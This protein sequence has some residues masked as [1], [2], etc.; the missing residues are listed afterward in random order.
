MGSTDFVRIASS[1]LLEAPEKAFSIK[2]RSMVGRFCGTFDKK[3]P[4]MRSC[5]DY[6]LLPIGTIV[7]YSAWVYIVIKCI[8]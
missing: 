7:K 6:P 2:I 8:L 3:I 1:L 5:R 4:L